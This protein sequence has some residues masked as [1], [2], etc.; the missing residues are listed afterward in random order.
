[1]RLWDGPDTHYNIPANKLAIAI[2]YGQ[3]IGDCTS[4]WASVNQIF[5]AHQPLEHF[6]AS[7]L[8]IQ[9]NLQVPVCT[10]KGDRGKSHESVAYIHEKRQSHLD[11]SYVC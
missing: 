5:F 9:K 6:I 11:C 1:M 3:L 2:S 8:G 7:D 4:V 10:F